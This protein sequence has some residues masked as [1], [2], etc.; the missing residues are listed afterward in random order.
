MKVHSQIVLSAVVTMMVLGGSHTV[1][2]Q[3]LLTRVFEIEH[4]EPTSLEITLALFSAEFS[5]NDDLKTL[6]VRSRPEIMTAI[7]ETITRLDVLTVPRAV[8]LTVHILSANDRTESDPLPAPVQPVVERLRRAFSYS[9]FEILDTLLLRAI[10][11]RRA[12]TQGTLRI[13]PFGT[14]PDVPI[15]YNFRANFTIVAPEPGARILKLTEMRSGFRVPVLQG[16]FQPQS[17]GDT[18]TPPVVPFHYTDVDI[19]TD[20]DIPEGQ[21]VV[22]GK[23]TIGESAI[24]LVMSADL[25]DSPF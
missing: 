7:E 14:L 21:H 9:N 2:G 24:I 10:D 20:V 18:D 4:L 17:A 8:E 3:G 1:E 16:N 12:S 19:N 25:L 15:F 6:T 23:A 13:P 5:S 22:V 11:G